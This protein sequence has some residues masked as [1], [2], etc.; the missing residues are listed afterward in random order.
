[1]LFSTDCKKGLLDIPW[2]LERLRVT[3]SFPALIWV[4][5]ENS[6]WKNILEVLTLNSWPASSHWATKQHESKLRGLEL[7]IPAI[8]SITRQEKGCHVSI[9][10]KTMK[11]SHFLTRRWASPLNRSGV[12]TSPYHS[13]AFCLHHCYDS[14]SMADVRSFLWLRRPWVPLKQVDVAY[15]AYIVPKLTQRDFFRDTTSKHTTLLFLSPN[16]SFRSGSQSKFS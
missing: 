6:K 3:S 13:S 4:I 8:F 15:M 12:A 10:G 14:K 2:K 5:G 7:R 1:M 11:Y 16:P 9:S